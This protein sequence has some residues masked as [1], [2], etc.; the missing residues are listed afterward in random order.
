[1]KNNL[2]GPCLIINNQDFD[3]QEGNLSTRTGAKIDEDRFEKLFKKLNFEIF[4]NK[5]LSN[6]TKNQIMKE[7][8]KEFIDEI[9]KNEEKYDALVLIIMTHGKSGDQLYGSDNQIFKVTV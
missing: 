1:M 7:D 5:I 2:T 4:K 3:I 8:L 6:R 9:K